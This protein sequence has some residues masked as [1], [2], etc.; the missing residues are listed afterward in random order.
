[1]RGCV[2]VF[3]CGLDGHVRVL[4]PRPAIDIRG[5]VTPLCVIHSCGRLKAFH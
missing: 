5:P 2:C 3:V 1:M 4:C